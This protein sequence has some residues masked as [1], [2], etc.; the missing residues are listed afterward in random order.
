MSS[1]TG[2]LQFVPMS[3]GMNRVVKTVRFYLS[4]DKTGEFVELPEGSITNFA[5]VPKVFQFI[6]KPDADD[7]RMPAAFHDV[8]VGEFGQKVFIRNGDDVVRMPTW[9][10]SAFW[11]RKMIEVR[12]RQTRKKY[13]GAKRHFIFGVD[14]CF[15]WACWSAVVFHGVVKGK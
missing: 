9:N 3:N 1:F 15:K 12:Q 5:S 10:E 11:F 8:L 6:F 14:Y 2:K 7:V 4:N 13:R